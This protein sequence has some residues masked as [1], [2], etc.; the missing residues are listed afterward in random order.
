[1]SQLEV[2]IVED[3]FI[4]ADDLTN[5]LEYLGYKV[6]GVAPSFY[7]ALEAIE[8]NKPNLCLLDISI[9][10][11]KD[12]I[13]LGKEINAR[14]GIPFLYITSHSDKVTVSRAKETKPKGYIVKPFDQDDVYTSI[15]IAIATTQDAIVV[16]PFILLRNKGKLEK[17]IISSIS[18]VKSDGNYIEIHTTD[19]RKYL[20]RQSLKE[21]L[22]LE[23]ISGFC[24]V[25]K[26]YAV[27]LNQVT[28]FNSKT[29]N[30]NSFEIPIGKT[31]ISMVKNSLTKVN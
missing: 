29:V 14:Y 13:D 18:F 1:M 3:N 17:L 5:I 20:Q 7:E 6:L 16:E 25:H 12:G 30:G 31:F 11:E 8:K 15:E 24:Q 10:G 23:Q 27:N 4:I 22:E 21:F 28:S 26:S 9:R 19:E 2:L